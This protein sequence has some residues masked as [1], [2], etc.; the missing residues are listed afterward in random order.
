M[1]NVAGF[2]EDA[3]VAFVDAAT[4]VRAKHRANFRKPYTYFSLTCTIDNFAQSS[5]GPV[6][7]NFDE[8]RDWHCTHKS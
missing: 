3:I 7:Q 2:A 1:L 4:L 5:L 8:L 6:E